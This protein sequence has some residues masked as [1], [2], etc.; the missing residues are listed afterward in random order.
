MQEY[1]LSV[2]DRVLLKAVGNL[3]YLQSDAGADAQAPI[4]MTNIQNAWQSWLEYA[5]GIQWNTQLEGQLDSNTNGEIT[6]DEFVAIV[7]ADTYFDASD[8]SFDCLQKYNFIQDAPYSQETKCGPIEDVLTEC[9]ATCLD[10]N[11]VAFFYQEHNARDGCDTAPHGGLQICAYYTTDDA[12][13]DERATY[14]DH[15]DGSQ[16]CYNKSI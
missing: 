13:D 10:Q 9:K 1:N 3:A 14:H 15:L 2:N 12:R 6:L 7:G 8:D 11:C 5:E 4:T 16:L